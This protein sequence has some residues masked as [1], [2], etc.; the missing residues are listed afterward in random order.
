MFVWVRQRGLCHMCFPCCSHH[1]CISHQIFRLLMRAVRK[2][3][4]SKFRFLVVFIAV[5]GVLLCAVVWSLRAAPVTGIVLPATA[6][7]IANEQALPSESQD[8]DHGTAPALGMASCWGR[9]RR[10]STLCI[11]CL[12]G[13]CI[14]RLRI[15][16]LLFMLLSWGDGGLMPKC[17]QVHMPI[18]SGKERTVALQFLPI[19]CGNPATRCH[20][21]VDIPTNPK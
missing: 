15:L 8:S 3:A 12:Q 9:T 21:A 11:V 19:V 6:S 16:S 14:R 13:I 2:H 5:I 7:Q 10:R 20:E 18:F 17:S 4:F 1:V